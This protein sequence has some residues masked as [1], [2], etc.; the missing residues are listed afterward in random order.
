MSGNRLASALS[1]GLSLYWGT[2]LIIWTQQLQW[3]RTRWP[4]VLPFPWPPDQTPRTSLCPRSCQRQVRWG[5][6]WWAPWLAWC[7]GLWWPQFPPAW[8]PLVWC[9]GSWSA[10]HTRPPPTAPAGGPGRQGSHSSCVRG[11]TVKV[12]WRKR[13]MEALVDASGTHLV[14]G[15]LLFRKGPE[16]PKAIFSWAWMSAGKTQEGRRWDQAGTN[17]HL[18]VSILNWS[19]WFILCSHNAEGVH[20][21]LCVS[22]SPK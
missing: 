7:H 1:I 14:N 19:N 18:E 15:D 2:Y 10:W 17:F 8:T 13:A 12:N 11:V 9:A 20:F 16:G 3:W 4:Q 5:P 22:S 21:P 6:W